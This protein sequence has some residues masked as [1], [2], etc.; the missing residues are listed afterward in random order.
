M[1]QKASIGEVGSPKAEGNLKEPL[2]S[3]TAASGKDTGRILEE[4]Q[5]HAGPKYTPPGTSAPS[6][7][8][9]AHFVPCFVALIDLRVPLV[10]E[11]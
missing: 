5:P 2:L 4:S 10:H 11:P 9:F 8:S 7:C 6:R 3:P 1:D